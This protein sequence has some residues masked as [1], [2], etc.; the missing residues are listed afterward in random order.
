LIEAINKKNVKN[1]VPKKIFENNEKFWFCSKCN[2][3]YWMGSHY[4]D[5]IKKAQDY[6]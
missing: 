6:T 2:K 1:K 4:N 5:I 3:Y